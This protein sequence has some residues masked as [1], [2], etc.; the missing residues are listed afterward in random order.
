MS[1]FASA[2]PGRSCPLHYRYG[3]AALADPHRDL[4]ADTLYV[5]GGLYGNT[6]ALDALD[7]LLAAERGPVCVLFNGDFHWFDIDPEQFGDVQRRVLAHEAIAGNVEAALADDDDEAGCGCAYP[8]DVPDEVV[9]RSNL[10]HARLSHT[11]R[12]DP[13]WR[14]ELAAL[15]YWRAVRVGDARIGVVHGDA[16]SLA[17]WS[18]DARALRD[19]AR[20]AEHAAAF[21][22]ARCDLFASSHT[23]LPA[24]ALFDEGAVINNGAAGMAS[25]HGRNHGIVT[26]IAL[27][28]SPHATLYGSRIRGL[29]VD[30]L[31]LHFDAQ[32]WFALFDAQWPQGSPA[33]L[34]YRS[35]MLNGPAWTLT[36]ATP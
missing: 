9:T 36:E 12:H 18:F 25:L 3:A 31:P 13:L 5:V 15:D 22:S 17:G 7:G 35:R 34:N 24:L 23:C 11:A 14:G 8:D 2:L 27:C 4:H 30:A 6:C 26:R 1:A 10:I 16:R 32:R 19:P 20:R 21:G 33:Q 29:H 28:A